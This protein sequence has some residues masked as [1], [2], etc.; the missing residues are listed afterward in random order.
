ML[1]EGVEAALIV[2]IVASFLRP[3][4][5]RSPRHWVLIGLGLVALLWF[6]YTE[7]SGADETSWREAPGHFLDTVARLRAKFGL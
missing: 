7:L 1:H 6:E 5:R 3:G 4:G 2:L